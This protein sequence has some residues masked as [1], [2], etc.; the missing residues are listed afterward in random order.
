VPVFDKVARRQ[1]PRAKVK[2][3]KNPNSVDQPLLGDKNIDVVHRTKTAVVEIASDNRCS[4]EDD[5]GHPAPVQSYKHVSRKGH[6]FEIPHPEK[7]PNAPKP[8]HQGIVDSEPG[9]VALQQ[10]QETMLAI[11]KRVEIEHRPPFPVSSYCCIS[12]EK[13]RPEE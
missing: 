11:S 7:S 13:R 2:F 8:V 4:L 1:I 3:C 10:R 5:E 12:I 6:G 9:Q